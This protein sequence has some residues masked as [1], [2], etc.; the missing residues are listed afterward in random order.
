MNKFHTFTFRSRLYMKVAEGEIT[1]HFQIENNTLSDVSH[2]HHMHECMLLVPV[3]K[4]DK[5]EGFTSHL[6]LS[7]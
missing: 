6:T 3:S 2:M 5:Y 4:N 1:S 7:I